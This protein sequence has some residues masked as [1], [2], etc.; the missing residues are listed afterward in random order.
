MACSV[1]NMPILSQNGP[2]IGAEID[3]GKGHGLDV[4]LSVIECEFSYLIRL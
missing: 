3:Y 4:N 1:E 2:L